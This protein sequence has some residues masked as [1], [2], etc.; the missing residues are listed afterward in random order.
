[1]PTVNPA[2]G[3]SIHEILGV[4]HFDSVPQSDVLK[5]AKLAAA[6]AAA[7]ESTVDRNNV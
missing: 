1:M 3:G 6:V 2:K 7:P 4:P 5:A